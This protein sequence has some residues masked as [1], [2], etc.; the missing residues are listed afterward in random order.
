MLNDALRQI[1]RYLNRYFMVPIFRLGLGG[2]MGNPLTSY[3]MVLKTIGRKSGKTR[4][5]PVNYAIANGCI[6]CLSGW[7]QTSD[8]Y[9]NLMAQ[10]EIDIIMP[11][12]AVHGRAELVT[13]PLERIQML[14]QVLKNAGFAGYLEGFD[15]RG[16]SD[17]ELE[18]KASV[19]QLLRIRPIGLGSGAFDPGGWSWILWIVLSVPMLAWWIIKKRR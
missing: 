15:P 8:W 9:R 1:F 7:G 3:V 18:H 6:Y 19:M 4:Y 2:F 16:V 11:S 5:A 12:G 10:P 14:R 17:E 13:D